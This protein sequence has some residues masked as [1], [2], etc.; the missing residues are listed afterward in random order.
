[1]FMLVILVSAF[2]NAETWYGI[3][4]E[5]ENRC[6]QYD[7]GDYPYEQSVELPN[8]N[9][10]DGKIYSMYTGKYFT[11]HKLTDD[12][13]IVALSETHDSGFCSASPDACKKY[14]SGLLNQALASPEVSRR[15]KRAHEAA[16]WLPTA[17][18]CWY[19]YKVVKVRLEF[20]LTIGRQEA[21]VLNNVLSTRNSYQMLFP[22]SGKERPGD[23]AATAE[24]WRGITVAEE[25]R[26]SQYDRGDYPYQQSVE[27]EIIERMD[28][29]I[30]DP[31]TGSIF[32]D[33]SQVVIEHIVAISEAHDS[34]L[35]KA[36]MY[37]RKLFASDL[38]NLTSASP[39]VNRK[40]WPRDAAEWLPEK[41]SCW[42]ADTVVKVRN[43]Y[44][45]TVDRKEA[46]ALE[47]VLSSCDSFDMVFYFDR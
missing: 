2:L 23:I 43:K 34:G 45:L 7:R 21:K 8:I 1:M 36:S 18:K 26:C 44:G 20:G 3:L 47:N 11:D 24:S 6:S 5:P 27:L 25:Y 41:N 29:R 35:C 30:F 33:R 13:S 16:V 9:I 40:K 15:L 37:V 39:S 31:Y 10:M 14:A 19:A 4:V 32:M 17:N 12:G 42:F 22:S 28:G 38:L 46:D